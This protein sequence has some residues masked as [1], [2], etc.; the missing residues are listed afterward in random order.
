[1]ACT[2]SIVFFIISTVSCHN[3]RGL[4]GALVV[5]TQQNLSNLYFLKISMVEAKAK[6]T[7]RTIDI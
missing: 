2:A 3:K 6:R 7:G 5:G 4:N 1:M